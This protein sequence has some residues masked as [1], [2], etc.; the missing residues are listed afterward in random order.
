[1]VDPVI[2]VNSTGLKEEL[3]FSKLELQASFCIARK[4][5]ICFP[6]VQLFTLS[7]CSPHLF[8][9]ALW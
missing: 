2:P 4:L 9:T 3:H 7:G 1:V 5:F 8:S 6:E